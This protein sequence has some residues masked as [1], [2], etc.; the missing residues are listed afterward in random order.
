[1]DLETVLG[2]VAAYLL[3]GMFFAF[4]YRAAARTRNGL[5]RRPGRRDLCSRPLLLVYD[6][7]DDGLG[8]L[9]P[10]KNPGQSFA[11]AEMFIGQL[12]LVTAV[13]EIINLYRPARS[14][15]QVPRGPT[16]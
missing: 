2:A 4:V 7:H 13:A 9:V 15:L 14:R 11:L 1:M 10:A 6:A 16:R 12:F 5:L 8:N 3:I